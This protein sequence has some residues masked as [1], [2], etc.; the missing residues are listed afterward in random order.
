M[1][2][3]GDAT[4]PLVPLC[5]RERPPSFQLGGLFVSTVYRV[6]GDSPRLIGEHRAAWNG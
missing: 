2:T 3:F 5:G 6:A 1:G 4:S